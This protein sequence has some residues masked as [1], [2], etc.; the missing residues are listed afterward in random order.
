M[1]YLFTPPDT[2]LGGY[3]EA[4]IEFEE[5]D[6]ARLQQAFEVIWSH[7]HVQGVYLDRY[8]EPEN[9]TRVVPSQIDP[10]MESA[11]GVMTL[12]SGPRLPFAIL[13]MRGGGEVWLNVSIPMGALRHA[14]GGVERAFYSHW[15]VPGAAPVAVVRKIEDFLAGLAAWVFTHVEFRRGFIGWETSGT[16]D[17][18]EIQERG[19]PEV[20]HVG[21]VLPEG[22][23]LRYYPRTAYPQL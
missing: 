10:W 21:Y 7:P 8:T 20:R 23:T 15:N 11:Q 12:P 2:W 5:M 3:F 1:T 9:Q 18:D 13:V 17:A 16:Q 19:I 6:D 4:S 14:V 22:S